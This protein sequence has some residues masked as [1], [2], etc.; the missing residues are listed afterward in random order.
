MCQALHATT[1]HIHST[2]IRDTHCYPLP[3]DFCYK[4]RVACCRV[5]GLTVVAW[6]ATRA[7]RLLLSAFPRRR[8][9]SDLKPEKPQ[10]P[11][12]CARMHL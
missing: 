6:T 12:A 3:F 5:S 11:A 1:H 10:R 2:A 9:D 7:A 4:I 8:A